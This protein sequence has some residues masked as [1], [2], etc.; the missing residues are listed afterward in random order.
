MKD[1]FVVY[2]HSGSQGRVESHSSFMGSSYLV[3][4]ENVP[5]LSRLISQLAC[6]LQ[7]RTRELSE[8]D[9]GIG[10]GFPLPEL[11]R[12]IT[13]HSV[14][15]SGPITGL[16]LENDKGQYAVQLLRYSFDC[17]GVVQG[18]PVPV[19]DLNYVKSVLESLEARLLE[20]RGSGV[21]ETRG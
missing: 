18:F 10:E 8:W 13:R 21:G 11:G 20:R 4:D 16:L 5:H 12:S 2:R 17:R 19:A 6:S 3:R 9:S 7:E 15:R 1:D 14:E